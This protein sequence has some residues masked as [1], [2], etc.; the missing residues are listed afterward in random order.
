[1][2]QGFLLT[3]GIKYWM[4]WEINRFYNIAEEEN[5]E[6]S[7][8][9][10]YSSV[11]SNSSDSADSEYLTSNDDSSIKSSLMR[12]SST[13]LNHSI[14]KSSRSTKSNKPNMFE[15]EDANG[16]GA[17]IDQE[18]RLT[19]G[20]VYRFRHKH[21]N[22]FNSQTVKTEKKVVRWSNKTIERQRVNDAIRKSIN[23]ANRTS[24]NASLRTSMYT[25][26]ADYYSPKLCIG[27]LLISYKNESYYSTAILRVQSDSDFIGI[28]TTANHLVKKTKNKKGKMI[29]T[30]PKAITLFI[31][32]GV[33]EFQEYELS[34]DNFKIYPKFLEQFYSPQSMRIA[35]AVADLNK[36]YPEVDDIE[37][38]KA[39]IVSGMPKLARNF[40]HTKGDMI[41]MIWYPFSDRKEEHEV[42]CKLDKVVKVDK[43]TGVIMYKDIVTIDRQAGAPILKYHDKYGWHI[44]GVHLGE[45]LGKVEGGAM[46][47]KTMK[48][49]IESNITKMSVEIRRCSKYGK[50][51]VTDF[52]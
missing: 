37:D 5:N 32:S 13:Y 25:V 41:K 1:M 24:N 4:K 22:L 43:A 12:R 51:I 27:L 31:Q 40:K 15:E 30:Y 11:E 48:K 7:T 26:K 16:E 49:W 38:F 39:R 18:P 29:L 46:V 8:S 45:V 42:D 35:V 14:G 21:N 19:R 28:I 50:E 3:E 17:G 36:A 2:K 47:T 23:N 20:H 10:S 44:V 6:S 33:E 52:E 34:V 9:N